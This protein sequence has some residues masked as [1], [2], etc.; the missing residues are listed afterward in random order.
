MLIALPFLMCACRSWSKVSLEPNAS[1]ALPDH[2]WVVLMSGARVPVEGGRFT[3]DSLIGTSGG[4]GRFAVSRDSVT[5]VEV[6][7]VSAMRT[8]GLAAGIYG[9]AA[10]VAVLVATALMGGLLT[11]LE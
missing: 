7:R 1:G 5:L 8:L 11:G 3:A 9:A 6:R 4:G 10:V 2:S